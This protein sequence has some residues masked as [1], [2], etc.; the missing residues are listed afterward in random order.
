MN[1]QQA[2]QRN[3][4]DTLKEL[5]KHQTFSNENQGTEYSATAIK[6]NNIAALKLL[7]QNGVHV[8]IAD[9]KYAVDK[10]FEDCVFELLRAMPNI[11]KVR[12]HTPLTYV[13]KEG[14]TIVVDRIIE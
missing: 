4:L 6:H 11:A 14:F 8:T 7:L 13:I 2:I 5:L 9:F 12:G 10:K 1:I 3:N